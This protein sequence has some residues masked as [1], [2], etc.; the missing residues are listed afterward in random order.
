[1]YVLKA[2]RSGMFSIAIIVLFFKQHGLSMKEITLLQSLFAVAVIALEVPTGYLA[3][4]YGK[5]KSIVIGGCFSAAGYFVYSLSSTFWGFLAGEF[6]LAVGY[7]CTSGADSA[8]ICD[9]SEKGNGNRTLIKNE[10]NG[11]SASM[12]SEAI[13]SFIGGSLLA[14]VS[15]RLP[16]FFDVLLAFLVLPVA[17]SLHEQ[18]KSK[19]DE[20]GGKKKR[21][22]M[23][24]VM[25]RLMKYSL[26]EHVE[27]KWLIIYSA[28]VSTSTL[29][30]VWFIQIYWVEAH[31]PQIMFG[32][33]WA[34]LMAVGAYVSLNVHA[35]EKRLGRKFSLIALIVLPVFAYLL[36]SI[37][38]SAIAIAFMTLFYVTR[39][40]NNPITKSY[41]NG[42]VSDEERATILSVQ[43]LIGR[44]MFAV[45]GPII[46]WVHD[47]YSLQAMLL[48]SAA[49]F[50]SMGA[51]ALLFLHKNRLL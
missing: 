44:L 48:C 27:I 45:I 47:T 12:A 11:M 13:T 34:S 25:V 43:S 26:H 10:G 5:K 6:L 3:D 37:H 50:A 49:L 16:I 41:I 18:P 8:I 7:C 29:T 15:L 36:L 9:N 17:L 33:L 42:L 1:M 40:M 23:L 28:V 51:I 46:G 38:V 4:N 20:K 24:K 35:I 31:V 30:M 14:L 21:E 39:G 22:S 2:L 19:E 32:V